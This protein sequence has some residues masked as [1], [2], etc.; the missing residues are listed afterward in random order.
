MNIFEHYVLYIATKTI[1]PASSYSSHLYI[2]HTSA[3][4][5]GKYA[6]KQH[7]AC[8]PILFTCVNCKH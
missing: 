7:L 8:N 3:R 4:R 5:V 2:Q 6:Y 1:V